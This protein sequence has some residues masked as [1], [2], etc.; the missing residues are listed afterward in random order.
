MDTGKEGGHEVIVH[1]CFLDRENALLCMKNKAKELQ[2]KY[3]ASLEEG[4]DWV[5]VIH[6]E[7]YFVF[8]IKEGHIS[9]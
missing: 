4:L 2:E 8:E 1:G 3:G 5:N 7:V 9:I 6:G